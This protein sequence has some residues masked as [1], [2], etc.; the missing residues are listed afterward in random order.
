VP[1]AQRPAHGLLVAKDGY[2]RKAPG[3]LSTAAGTVETNFYVL[4]HGVLDFKGD[5]YLDF[6]ITSSDAIKQAAGIGILF[7][8]QICHH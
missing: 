8:I 4:K 7:A 6:D 3:T 1:F 5:T 2:V